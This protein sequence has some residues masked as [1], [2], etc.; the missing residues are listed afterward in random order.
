MKDKQEQYLYDIRLII[1]EKKSHKTLIGNDDDVFKLF[2]N[3]KENLLK[4]DIDF[5]LEVTEVGTYNPQRLTHYDSK[6]QDDIAVI[7]G[8]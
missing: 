4:D 5:I 3:I 8:E 2:E 7:D 6:L 1:D